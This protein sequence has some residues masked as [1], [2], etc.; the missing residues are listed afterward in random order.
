MIGIVPTRSKESFACAEHSLL[1]TAK[2]FAVG[3]INLCWDQNL[4]G[5]AQAKFRK[6]SRGVSVRSAATEATGSIGGSA[7]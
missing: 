5:A 6:R 1:Q 3:K 4:I 7:L 2:V